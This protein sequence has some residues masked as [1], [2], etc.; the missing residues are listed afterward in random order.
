M[1]RRKR[2]KYVVKVDEDSLKRKK[3]TEACC[4]KQRLTTDRLSPESES[5]SSSPRQ[6]RTPSGKISGQFL[7]PG[8]LSVQGNK[9][10]CQTKTT[11]IYANML[12]ANIF[13]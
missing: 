11:F 4:L 9:L 2:K 8:R 3:K 12:T 10:L 6:T 13:D 5:H 1:Q 7:H